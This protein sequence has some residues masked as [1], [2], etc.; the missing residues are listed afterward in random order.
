MPFKRQRLEKHQHNPKNTKEPI[1]ESI[2]KETLAGIARQTGPPV[3]GLL[4]DIYVLERLADLFSVRNPPYALNGG[5]ALNMIHFGETKRVPSDIDLR[6]DDLEEC[7]RAFSG[8]FEQI[9]KPVPV[10][11]YCF[12]DEN[13]IE[14]DLSQ[15]R[16]DRSKKRFQATSILCNYGLTQYT[17]DVLSY[18]FEIL[19]AEKIIA[20]ARKKDFKDLY[21]AY[22][23]MSHEF[24]RKKLLYFLA[25]FRDH[26][27]ID[28]FVIASSS[29][30]LDGGRGGAH[31]V[32][33]D[34]NENEILRKVQD[35][36][37]GFFPFL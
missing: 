11:A 2:Q 8:V 13:G 6:C 7:R 36:V 17:A 34:L 24:D 30:L 14:I 22:V 29:F 9:K 19:F 35:F 18:D 16:F 26:D 12:V 4:R 33:S 27:E 15:N 1:A 28:P 20:L 21:D 25:E 37:R 5:A 23:C 3:E 31:H 32:T 10:E